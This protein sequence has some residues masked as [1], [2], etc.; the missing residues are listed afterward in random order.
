MFFRYRLGAEKQAIQ[1]GQTRETWMA[2]KLAEAEVKKPKGT[3]S[4]Q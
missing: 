3:A 4:V 2:Q 1:A